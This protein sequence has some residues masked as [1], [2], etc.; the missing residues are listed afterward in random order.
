MS[1]MYEEIRDEKGEWKPE[2]SPADSP[3]FSWPW[4]L[5]KILKY[6]F[7]PQGFF[8]PN[9]LIYALIAV[10]SWVYFTPELS[11]AETFSFGWIAEIYLR[12]TVLL[13]LIVGS[14]HLRLY[15]SKAQ[16]ERYKYINKWMDKGNKK[17]LF[18]NQVWDNIFWS[19]TSGSIIWTAY[20]AL[21]LWMYANGRLPYIDFKSH[22]VYFI[23][24][25]MA[26]PFL[27]LTHFYFIHKWSH[28]KPLYKI[29]HY[30][31]H[32]NI[33][34]GPWSGLSMHPIEHLLYFSGILIHWVIPS[35]PI[36]GIFHLM[37]AGLSPAA[38]HTG[39]HK[40]VLNKKAE[41]NT[42]HYFHYLHHKYFTVNF[43]VESVP[44]DKWFGSYHDGSDKAHEE[45]LRKRKNLKG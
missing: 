24:L 34:I 10:M 38:G 4:N 32:K 35:H 17:F 11:R 8:F 7:G 16:G 26:I 29:S 12:N 3:L 21:T 20:E 44:L 31:H 9:N 13:I 15:M 37:H 14:L 43:G 30:L 5:K 25:M 36:H 41:W 42:D 1:D 19:L 33:N 40:L 22:P 39:F 23:L 6:Y 28:W 45:M 2:N 27:R 18:R